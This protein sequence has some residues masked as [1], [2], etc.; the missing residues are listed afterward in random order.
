MKKEYLTSHGG[1]ATTRGTYVGNAL[2]MLLDLAGLCISYK[3]IM[4][5]CKSLHE[6]KKK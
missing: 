6:T 2:L 3:G 5:A 1:V 4:S